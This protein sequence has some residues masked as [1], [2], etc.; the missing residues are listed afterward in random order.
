MQ[1]ELP[2]CIQRPRK[3]TENEKADMYND[4]LLLSLLGIFNDEEAI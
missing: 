1:K 4:K 3:K 2:S